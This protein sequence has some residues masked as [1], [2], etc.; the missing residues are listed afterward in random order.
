MGSR[1]WVVGGLIFAGIMLGLDLMTSRGPQ[2]LVS[3]ALAENRPTAAGDYVMAATRTSSS[4]EV[5]YVADVRLKKLVVYATR[6]GGRTG[7]EVLDGRDL[8]A[9]MPG[10]CSGQ[11]LLQPFYISDGT[12]AIAV[13][14]VVS[15]KMVIYSN[16][17]YGRLELIGAM[18]VKND[19]GG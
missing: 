5:V 16:R 4:V 13:L 14:D 11:V 12:G 7:V 18:D 19:M 6:R 15:R 9:D 8:N 2:I 1:K 17:N 3:D 10:G